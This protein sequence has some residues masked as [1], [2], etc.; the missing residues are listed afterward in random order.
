MIS[1]AKIK[2]IRSLELKKNRQRE[3]VFV[4]EGPKAVGDFLKTRP[5]LFIACTESWKN[6]GATSQHPQA[7]ETAIVSHEEL[8]KISFM[9]HPQEVLALFPIPQNNPH[10]QPG[11]EELCL[12]LDDVQDPGNLGTII[13]IAHWFGISRIYCSPG[14]ADAYNPKTVQASMGSLAHVN[15]VYTPLPQLIS[16]L[17]P[18]YPVYGTLLNG[19]NIYH[20]H[21]T[22]HGLIIMGNEGSGIS[23]D[24]QSQ[25][26]QR[27]RIPNYPPE[28]P[29]ADSLNVSVAAAVVCSEFRRRQHNT[30]NI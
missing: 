14:T 10:S 8:C 20:T 16:S 29:T 18:H 22:P 3:G 1:K 13:R 17:P 5:A 7:A 4:A 27:L 30:P 12:A 26:T 24:L 2:Y 28:T 23:V 15:L 6:S 9:Q 21:L 11:S 25:I 19:E